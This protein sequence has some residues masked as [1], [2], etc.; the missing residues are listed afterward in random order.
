MPPSSG[1]LRGVLKATGLASVVRHC[2]RGASMLYGTVLPKRQFV[3]RRRFWERRW[4]SEEYAPIFEP[5]GAIP[6]EVSRAMA[7]TWPKPPARLLDIGCGSGW[8]AAWLADQGYQVLGVDYSEAAIDRARQVYP[9]KPAQLEW[10]VRDIL[11]DDLPPAEFDILLDR[12]CL[13]RIPPRFWP[14]YGRR[15]RACAKVGARFLL[16]V[17]TFEH[18]EFLSCDSRMSR[19]EVTRRV[20]E[21]CGPH[22]KMDSVESTVLELN[23]DKTGNDMPA[24]AFWMT[25]K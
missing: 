1:A 8:I 20:E 11:N 14:Q 18:D 19:E 22:F 4:G 12:G 9:E 6:K 23:R 10:K 7:G 15:L 5:G 24:V 2:R 3:E 21:A 16:L 17:A 25:A 13:H